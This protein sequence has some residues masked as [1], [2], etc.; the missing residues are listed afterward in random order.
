VANEYA[1][2]NELK[3]W[4]QVSDDQDDTVLDLAL[5]AASRWVESYCRRRFY[6]DE[7]AQALELGGTTDDVLLFV[8]DD[9]RAHEVGSTDG[10]VVKTDDDGSGAFATTW[11]SD[12]Y[13][14]LP[15]NAPAAWPE[16]RPYTALRALGRSWPAPHTGA[17][18]RP[19]RVQ[20]TAKYGWP[21]VPA[22]V[23]EATLY[24]AAALF[25][26]RYSPEGVASFGDFA[27]RLTMRP[28]PRVGLLLREYRHLPVG[29]A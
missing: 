10:L 26:G 21:A 25:K 24:Q 19:L 18:S 16:A 4:V 15:R 27:I 2:R 12:E 3:T 20:L 5:T 22:A 9:G 17:T 1:T 28:D 11:A 8:D 13:E 23:K 7:A 14:L 29:I 6:L